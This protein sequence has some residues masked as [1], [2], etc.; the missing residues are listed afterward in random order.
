MKNKYF[1]L[2]VPRTAGSSLFA[3]FNNIL[4][5]KQVIWVEDIDNFDPMQLSALEKYLL[6]AGHFTVAHQKDYF[7]HRYSIVF[8]RNP[9][10][11]FISA[12]Y[13]FKKYGNDVLIRE[14]DLISYLDFCQ[15]LGC[16]PFTLFNNQTVYLTGVMD[17]SVPEKDL[18]D[19]AKENLSKIDFVGISEFFSESVGLLLKDCRWPPAHE[20]PYDNASDTRPKL[21]KF[22]DKMLDRIGELNKIDMELY[23]YGINLF[24]EKKRNILRK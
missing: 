19:M 20:I 15:N 16:Y 12:Y 14:M 2:H 5:Y 22:D 18:L 4:G 6:I 24:S 11:R 21:H 17:Y 23:K 1:F 9:V 3:L 8:L 7:S 13:Y 10:D